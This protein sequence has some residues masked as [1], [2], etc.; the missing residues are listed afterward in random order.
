MDA[1]PPITN[2]AHRIGT[3]AYSVGILY[4]FEDHKQVSCKYNVYTTSG[5]AV[6]RSTAKRPLLAECVGEEP[7]TLASVVSVSVTGRTL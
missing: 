4:P 3:R 7:H 2:T 5:D 6:H 1:P